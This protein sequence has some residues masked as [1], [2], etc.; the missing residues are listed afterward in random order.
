MKNTIIGLLFLLTA[1]N[2]FPQVGTNWGVLGSGFS[3]TKGI[4]G[5]YV[6][7]EALVFSYET[8]FGLGFSVSPLNM[9]HYFVGTNNDTIAFVNVSGYFDFLKDDSLLLAP[10]AM[11]KV[12]DCNKFDFVE[13][14][15]GIKFALNNLFEIFGSDK[16]ID[17]LIFKDLSLMVEL[18]YNYN[19]DQQGYYAH[20][21]IDIIS[22]LF[23]I[24]YGRF[25]GKSQNQM[26]F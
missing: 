26:K 2:V 16:E 6:Y 5:G 8:N 13:L 18:G 11:L 21:G 3:G 15:G 1:I 7:A 4:D 20:I 25:G 19:K 17:S 24:G 9:Q 10:F 22:A 12:I 14:R 23:W